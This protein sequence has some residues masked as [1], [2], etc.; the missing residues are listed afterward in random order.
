MKRKT[1]IAIG[2]VIALG[3]FLELAAHASE[4]NEQTTLTF[5]APVQIP[6]KVLPAGTYIFQQADPDNP[7]IVEV[8]DADGTHV[9]AT[10]QT[11]T[12]GRK[13][14]SA[15]VT[16]T[17]ATGESGTPDYLVNWYYPG[18]LTGHRFVYSKQQEEQLAQT[19]KQTFVATSQR[20]R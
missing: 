3:L 12:A 7:N 5:S 6:G 4:S 20:P 15:E 2:L 17:L 10:L 13:Q 18:H 1:Y 11:P 19:P 14:A 9:L 8:F 16:V